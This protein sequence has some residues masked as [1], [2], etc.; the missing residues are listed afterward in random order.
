MV[1]NGYANANRDEHAN[2]DADAWSE[3]ANCHSGAVGVLDSRNA[4]AS[5]VRRGPIMQWWHGVVDES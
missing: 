1:A 5:S 4:D 3:H 2:M